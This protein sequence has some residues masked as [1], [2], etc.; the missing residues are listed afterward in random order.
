MPNLV[1]F[2]KLTKPLPLRFSRSL[3][4]KNIRPKFLYLLHVSAGQW[5]TL[6]ILSSLSSLH[7]RQF[8]PCVCSSLNIQAL[9]FVWSVNSPTST[10]CFCLLTAWSSFVLLGRGSLIG[11]LDRRQPLQ[12]FHFFQVFLSPMT[13]DDFFA[14]N[15]GDANGLVRTDSVCPFLGQFVS[16]FISRYSTMPGYPYESDI[17]RST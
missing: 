1:L 9:K 8:C 6:C 12:V 14:H 11:V 13:P 15:N 7:S 4:F 16:F 10:W 17:I 2:T 3:C 5:P